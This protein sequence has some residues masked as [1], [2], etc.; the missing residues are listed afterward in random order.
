MTGTAFAILARFITPPMQFCHPVSVSGPLR[1][2]DHSMVLTILTILTFLLQFWQFLTFLDNFNNFGQFQQFWTISTIFD[3]FWQFWQLGIFL[4]I[5][6]I[7][8]TVLETGDNWEPELMKIIV[9]LTINYDTGQHSQFLR[10][11]IL[12]RNSQYW[13]SKVHA[14][15][16]GF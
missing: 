12:L 8:K 10:C 3:N 2:T 4:T 6:T 15:C 1:L 7:E 16:V 13:P 5:L 14:A 11:L 9:Y